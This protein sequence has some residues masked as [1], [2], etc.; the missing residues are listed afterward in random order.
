MQIENPLSKKNIPIKESSI[1]T[2][3]LKPQEDL[4]R[5]GTLLLALEIYLKGRKTLEIAKLKNLR[6]KL[7]KIQKFL[8]NHSDQKCRS[9]CKTGAMKWRLWMFNFCVTFASYD[10]VSATSHV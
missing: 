9:F 1:N 7:K 2:S 10:L 4:K 5:N 8:Q 6:T 3:D